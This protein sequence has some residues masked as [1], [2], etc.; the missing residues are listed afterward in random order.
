MAEEIYA[1]IKNNNVVN[2]AYFN[3]PTQELLTIFKEHHQVDL[4]IKADLRTFIGGTYD[5]TNFWP[6]P[7]FPSWIKNEETLEW[8]APVPKPNDDLF[9]KWNEDTLEWAIY[10]L[11]IIE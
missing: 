3:N 1:F 11:P 8:E 4:I 2:I 6:I 10:E 7:P 5:G 9:Y